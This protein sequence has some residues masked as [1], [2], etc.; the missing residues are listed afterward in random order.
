L[1]PVTHS[2]V[3]TEQRVASLIGRG[4]LPVPGYNLEGFGA[5]GEISQRRRTV[6]V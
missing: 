5:L 6:T 4:T 1:Y 3:H 2:E